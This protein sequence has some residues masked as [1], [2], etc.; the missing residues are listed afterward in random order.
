LPGENPAE[1]RREKRLEGTL[2]NLF[3]RYLELHAK[4]HKGP[5]SVAE[6]EALF[7]RY[8]ETWRNRRLSETRRRDVER[9]HVGVAEQHGIFAANRM[10]ALLSTMFNKSLEWGWRGPNPCKGVRKF[11]EQSR[12]RFVTTDEMPRFLRALAEEPN[13]DFRDIVL[14]GLLTGARKSNI[15]EMRWHD[16]DLKAAAWRI[17]QTKGGKSQTVPLVTPALCCLS[18]RRE[19][20]ISEWVFPGSNGRHLVAV[21]KPWKRLAESASVRDLRLHDVRRSLGSWMNKAGIGLPTIKKAL[22]HSDIATTQI[23]AR[24][25]DPEVR[26]A[27]EVT[28]Q[29]MLGARDG[30]E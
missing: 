14:L 29:R 27:L 20:S 30:H 21:A 23:Y 10:L 4:P 22:G 11:P 26:Q 6:D 18:A 17:P 24:S 19:K 3:D 7:R 25:E 15:L 1:D 9:L 12:E 13:A 5:R 2:G 28:A 8:L 16:I